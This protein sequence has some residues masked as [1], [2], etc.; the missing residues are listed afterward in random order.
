MDKLNAQDDPSRREFLKDFTTLPFLAVLQAKLSPAGLV[1]AFP[2]TQTAAT[3][4]AGKS[5]RKFVAIQTGGRSFMDEGVANVLDVLQEKAG[6]NVLMPAVFIY[7]RGLA[8][9]QVPSWSERDPRD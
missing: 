8:G 7:G 1:P 5:G 2:T 4:A 9:R 6:V 3:S